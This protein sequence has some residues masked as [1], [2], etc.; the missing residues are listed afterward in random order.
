MVGATRPRPR[1]KGVEKLHRGPTV[2]QHPKVWT[3]G[4]KEKA[5]S[6]KG[7]YEVIQ[8]QG[9][10]V[11]DDVSDVYDFHRHFMKKSRKVAPA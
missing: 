2:E 8:K 7:L 3:I 9:N 10:R 6:Q 1:D 11:G 5:K 4:Q